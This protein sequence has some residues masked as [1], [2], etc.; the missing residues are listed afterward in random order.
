M[1]A[2]ATPIVHPLIALLDSLLENRAALANLRRGLGQPR[3]MAPDMHRYLMPL[4]PERISRWDEQS[5]YLV[6]ALYGLHPKSTP[7]GNLGRHFARV[8]AQAGESGGEAVERRF[9]ALL[10]AHPD[11]LD[12]HLRQAVGL[13]KAKEEIPVNWQQLLYDVM[14]WGRPDR[15][16]DVQRRWAAGFWRR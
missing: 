5:Y 3:S 4:L 16:S 9:V 10:D 12:F 11:D 13:L 15:R 8:L 6:A 7:T 1:T 14:A 2:T